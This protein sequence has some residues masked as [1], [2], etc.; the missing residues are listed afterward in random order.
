MKRLF[1]LLLSIQLMTCMCVSAQMTDSQ[2]SDYIRQGIENGKGERELGRELLMR[3]VTH[4]QLERIRQQAEAGGIDERSDVRAVAEQNRERLTAP[5]EQLTAGVADVIVEEV[6]SAGNGPAIY[7]HDIFNGRTLSFE[8]NANLSTPDNYRLGPGDEVIIDIWGANEVSVRET[9]S[10]EGDIMISQIGPVYLNGLTV[11]AANSKLRQIFAS[12]Y[13]GVSGDDPASDVRVT[14]GRI[15][16]IQVNIMGEVHTPGTFRISGFST[17]FHAIYTAGGVSQNGSLRNIR[18]MRNGKCAATADLYEYL[19]DGRMSDDIRLQEGDVIIVPTY[20]MLVSVEGCVKRPM[21][22][23]MKGGETL[24]KLIE[25]AGGFTGNAYR[26]ELRM[27]RENGRERQIQ[28]VRE[29]ELAGIAL[30]DGDIVTV[31]ETL[32]RFANKVEVRGAVYRPGLYELGGRIA[33]VRQLVESA[34]GLTEDAFG[35][36]A[37]LMREKEDLSPEILS[38]DIAAVVTGKADDILL[39]R[40]DVLVISSIHELNDKGVLRINGEVSR[41]G[42]YDY[43]E[44]MT[45]ED[46]I[47]QAGG[48]LESAST[49]RIDVSRRVKNP[50]STEQSAEIGIIYSFPVKDGFAVDGRKDFVLAPYDIVDVRRSPAYEEQRAVTIQGEVLFPGSYTLVRKNERISDIIARAGGVSDDAYLRGARLI[51]RISDEERAT[52]ESVRRIAES[53]S[54]TDSMNM[55]RLALGHP[56]DYTVGIEL[57]KALDKPGSDY[58]VV[59]QSGDRVV[60]PEQVSTVRITGDVMQPNTV[61]YIGGKSPSYYINQSGGFAARAKKNKVYVVYMNGTVSRVKLSN[62]RCIEPGCQI[63]VPGKR[64]RHRMSVGEIMGLTTSAASVGTMAASIANLAK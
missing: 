47:I 18:V 1:T 37:L 5:A 62:K 55:S 16:N 35:M 29:A 22:Y 60:I 7:G 23:E 51:R 9:I 40:N 58:D 36:R 28:T 39:R 41:P 11:A 34:D 3:G 38:V 13:S 57:D 26:N 59:L 61:S 20:E 32:D 48:L 12:K 31:G 45:L 64:Q 24:Q 15:R 52:W 44:G 10:P 4:E 46:L 42:A 8:P 2:V 56:T 30:R 33:T 53:N 19:F 6:K 54:S 27:V 21:H 50:G 63:V 43:A 49:A 25:Y 14:L 17:L